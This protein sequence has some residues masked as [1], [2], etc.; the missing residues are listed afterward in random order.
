VGAA[1]DDAVVVDRGSCVHDRVIIDLGPDGDVRALSHE[2]A[3][4][5]QSFIGASGSRM[6]DVSKAGSETCVVVQ[7]HLASFLVL[8]RTNA[9]D[10]AIKGRDV[11]WRVMAG[12]VLALA[13]EGPL[14]SG[15][16]RRVLDDSRMSAAADDVE[17][18]CDDFDL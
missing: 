12:P 17:S 11:G 7:G 8:R 3:A 1:T 6:N 9:A 14:P 15:L 13:D 10:K 2:D 4:A 5:A 18:L 16:L